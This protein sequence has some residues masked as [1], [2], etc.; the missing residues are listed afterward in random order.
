MKIKKAADMRLFLCP[1]VSFLSDPIALK[2]LSRQE[3]F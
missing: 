3:I 2:I 1:E